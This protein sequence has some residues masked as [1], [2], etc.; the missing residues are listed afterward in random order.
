ML[1]LLLAQ[2]CRTTVF[3]SESAD[4]SAI[5]NHVSVRPVALQGLGPAFREARINSKDKAVAVLAL[6]SSGDLLSVVENSILSLHRHALI[7]HIIDVVICLDH[8][9]GIQVHNSLQNMGFT[10]FSATFST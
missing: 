2:L 7:D 10:H 8:Y 9:P 4:P 1:G 3:V 5:R 6:P